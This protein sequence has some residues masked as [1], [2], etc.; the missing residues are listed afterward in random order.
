V[1]DSASTYG[2]AELL[3]GAEVATSNLR[4]KIP[5]PPRPRRSLARLK[6]AKADPLQLRNVRKLN[7]SL[8]RFRE[9]KAEGV[10]GG[11]LSVSVRHF[12]ECLLLAQSG[13][14]RFWGKSGHRMGPLF[15]F[16]C[17]EKSQPR[18]PK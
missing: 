6:T 1:I 13:H 11:G 9:W 7:Q 14:I 15:R 17:A 10:G 3:M 5:T 8:S 18:L 2:D 4:D 12:A 16:R